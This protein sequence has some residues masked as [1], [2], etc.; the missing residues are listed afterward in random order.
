MENIFEQA[1][2]AASKYDQP[3]DYVLGANVAGFE[4]VVEVMRMHG[5]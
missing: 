1:Q 3:T 4:K 2:V 5:V